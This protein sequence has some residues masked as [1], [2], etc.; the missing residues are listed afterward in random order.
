MSLKTP[1]T[2]RLCSTTPVSAGRR[3]K[4]ASFTSTGQST[5]AEVP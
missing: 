5:A 3:V 2:G 4:K 1:E